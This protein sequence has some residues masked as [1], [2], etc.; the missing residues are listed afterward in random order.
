MEGI[1]F[2]KSTLNPIYKEMLR[3]IDL[4]IYTAENLHYLVNAL[5]SNS[6]I[7][8]ELA[9]NRSEGRNLKKIAIQKPQELAKGA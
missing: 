9:M 8:S 3:S 7:P 1:S 4:E 2:D 5:V 6:K